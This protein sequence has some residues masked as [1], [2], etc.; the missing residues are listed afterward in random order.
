MLLVYIPK[1]EEWA[2]E[3]KYQNFELS[4]THYVLKIPMC[5][6]IPSN[7]SPLVITSNI[8][9]PLDIFLLLDLQL[10]GTVLQGTSSSPGWVS[11]FSLQYS[12]FSSG[13]VNMC[14]DVLPGTFGGFCLSF[15]LHGHSISAHP[16]IPGLSDFL[17][18][19][20]FLS[21]EA[22]NM[23]STASLPSNI[24]SKIMLSSLEYPI[25]EDEWRI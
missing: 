9:G 20:Y 16:K 15:S 2:V 22:V 13:Q 7:S 19:T 24:K 23:P 12:R 3:F 4:N 5:L 14:T 8:C 18:Y 25:V 11:D 17:S 10:P 6:V 21:K 1:R